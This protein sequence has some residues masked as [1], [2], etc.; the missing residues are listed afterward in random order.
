MILEIIVVMFIGI[1]CGCITGLIPGLHVNMIAALLLGLILQYSFEIEFIYLAVFIVS[2]GIT[3]TFISFIPSLFLGVPTPDTVVSMLPGHQL[4]SQGRGYEALQLCALGSLGGLLMLSG[5]YV[6]AYFFITSIYESVYEHIGK[7]LLILVL[8][9]IYKEEDTNSRF[10]AFVIVILS[11]GFGLIVLNSMYVSNPLFLIFT[12]MFGTAALL[13]ALIEKTQLVEQK[14]EYVNIFRKEYIFGLS[15]GGVV[16]M[17]CSIAPGIGNAQAGTIAMN[18]L[19]KVQSELMIVVLSS[20]NTVNFGLS[21]LTLY[22]IERARNGTI[23]IFQELS[24]TLN[25]EIVII[26]CIVMICVGFIAYDL[27]FVL[28]KSVITLVEKIPTATLNITI[29]TLLTGVVILISNVSEIMTYF[30]SI[31][32][33]IL[34]LQVGVRRVHLMSVLLIPIIIFLW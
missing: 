2:L 6:L 9:L 7:I 32:L 31:C 33:G 5:I 30:A 19:R 27:V 11:G 13:V 23:I 29:A 10:W 21:I 4:V 17:L 28:G 14:E 26:L 22:L 8:Y 25:L 34:C 18:F 20:I 24:Y 15:V 12:G 16:A 1:L 3:H